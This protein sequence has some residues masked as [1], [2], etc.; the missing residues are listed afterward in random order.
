LEGID[1]SNNYGNGTA[2]GTPVSKIDSVYTIPSDGSCQFSAG[3]YF[4]LSWNWSGTAGAERKWRD[5]KV[6]VRFRQYRAGNIIN[7]YDCP[8]LNVVWDGQPVGRKNLFVSG[9]QSIYALTGDQIDVVLYH[10]VPD[11]WTDKWEYNLNQRAD[12]YY[13]CDGIDIGGGTLSASSPY[14]YKSM[15]I[16]FNYPLSLQ[17]YLTIRGSK[18]GMVRVPINASEFV[19]GWIQNLKYNHLGGEAAFTLITDG[20]TVYR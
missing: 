18:Q 14:N 5:K 7:T 11:A 1:Q 4:Y 17:E 12:S 15:K 3:I 10:F 9:S 19:Q 20:N 8:Y 13:I 2:Q 6:G 16:D